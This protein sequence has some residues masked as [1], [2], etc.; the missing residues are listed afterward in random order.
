MKTFLALMM[1]MQASI[2]F[3]AVSNESWERFCAKQTD[4]NTI[5]YC[6]K[7]DRVCELAGYVSE[8]CDKAR[9]DAMKKPAHPGKLEK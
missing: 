8:R 2:S 7:V 1:V 4:S 9:Q 3:A 5:N 6:V